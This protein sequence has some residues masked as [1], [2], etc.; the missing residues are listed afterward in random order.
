MDQD[1]EETISSREHSGLYF[2][3]SKINT[4]IVSSGKT[5]HSWSA[6]CTAE[7]KLKY[8]LTEIKAKIRINVCIWVK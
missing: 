2:A 4:G 6:E 1:G 3:A 8:K 5:T 7:L